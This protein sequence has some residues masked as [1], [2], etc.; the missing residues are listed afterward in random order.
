MPN[1][2]CKRIKELALPYENE[3]VCFKWLAQND[4]VRLIYT[5]FKD[6]N[7][8]IQISRSQNLNSQSSRAKLNTPNS[9]SPRP[10]NLRPQN[11]PNLPAQNVPNSRS[12]NLPALNPHSQRAQNLNAPFNDEFV[13]KGEKHSKPERV[14]YLQKALLVFKERFCDEIISEALALKRTRLLEKSEFIADDI[15]CVLEKFGKFSEISLEIGFGS[16]RHLL[17]Q[18]QNNPHALIIGAEIYTPAIEQVAKLAKA[19]NLDNILLIK[20]DAR[21]LLSVLPSNSLQKIFLHFPVPWDKQEHR[22]VV[23]AGFAEEVLRVLQLN[24]RFEL[25][26]DSEDYFE[27]S[28]EFFLN[29]PN[30]QITSAKNENLSITSKY[31]TR[32]KKQ[33]KDIY[34]LSVICQQ[35]SAPL[36]ENLGF[37]RLNLSFGAK[38]IAQIQQNFMPKHFRGKDFFI[39]LEDCYCV[40]EQ[41]LLLKFVFGAFDRNEHGYLLLNQSPQFLFKEPFYTKENVKALEK[42][43]EFLR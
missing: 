4:D 32:W 43:S 13:I 5:S 21:L 8:F 29:L 31:E 41:N 3:G 1:F 37:K 16:G 10:Q 42:L 18:A 27:F 25:R 33:D 23:S 17:Y 26:T 2:K 20:T 6:A 19:Q 15:A 39:R 34:D 14:G 24:G 11:A 12:Q 30:T 22:R 9:Q 7:F 36:S 35:E 40:D 38:K 28:K